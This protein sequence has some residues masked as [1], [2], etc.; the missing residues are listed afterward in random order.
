MNYFKIALV[1]MS[2]ALIPVIG[3]AVES[4]TIGTVL[5]TKG[6]VAIL[7][8]GVPPEK[9]AKVKD[10]LGSKDIVKTGADSTAQLMLRN[11][12]VLIIDENTEIDLSS[13]LPA[14]EALSREERI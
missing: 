14:Q 1:V 5:A 3:L 2:C 8:G 7:P 12:E 4:E 11:D 6:K 10:V 13:Y 9:P